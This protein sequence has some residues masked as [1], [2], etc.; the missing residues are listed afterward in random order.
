MIPA[1][2]APAEK[3]TWGVTFTKSYA[4]YL[5]LDWQEAYLAILDDLKISS[6]R[7]GINWDEIEKEKG[8]FDFEDYD[9][10][11]READKRGIEILPVVGLKT[12]RWPECRAPEWA[13]QMPQENFEAAQFAVIEAVVNHFKNYQNIRMWQMENEAFIEWF[14][15]CPRMRDSLARAKVKFLRS[16]D[17]VR[18]ILMTESGELSTWLKSALVTDVLGISLYRRVYNRWY[19]YSDYWM[20]SPSF[21]ARKAKVITFVAKLRR[22]LAT[23][24]I[25]RPIVTE[26]QLEAWM[27]QGALNQPIDEQLRYMSPQ[28]FKDTI[29][30]ARRTGF[31]VFYGWGAEWWYW[32]KQKGYPDLWSAAK[33]E[34]KR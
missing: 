5:G 7:V 21:Y 18:P 27:P 14:G 25:T 31:G 6:V 33:E 26:L 23:K 34:F 2:I 16:L 32:L 4:E 22:S 9:W 24:V 1:R 17:P 12:P 29:N 3:I 20:I 28:F 10:M 19:G 8:V 30:Y 13:W 15:E 11:F